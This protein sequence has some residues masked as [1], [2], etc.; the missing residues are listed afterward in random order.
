MSKTPGTISIRL[1]YETPC[2]DI[3]PAK[4]KRLVRQVCRQF[5]ISRATVNIAL[6][7][8]KTI[9]TLHKKIFRSAKITDVISFDLSDPLEKSRFFDIIINA[10]QARRQARRRGHIAQAEAALYLVHGLLHQLGFNDATEAQARRMHLQ[11]DE[12]L[13]DAGFGNVYYSAKKG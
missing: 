11:E 9:R 7:S 10:G 6:V 4:L 3:A 8:D 12:I 2:H 1:I 5:R 13:R